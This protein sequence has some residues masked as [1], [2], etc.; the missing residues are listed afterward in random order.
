MR[1]LIRVAVAFVAA[2]AAVI[3]WQV[4]AVAASAVEYAVM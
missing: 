4:A 3:A 2:T 1:N